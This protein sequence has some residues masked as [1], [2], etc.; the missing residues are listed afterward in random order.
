MR[1]RQYGPDVLAAGR[2]RPGQRELPRVAAVP[3]LV[4]ED[5][6]A[7]FCGAVVWC[8]KDAV[9]LEDA[10]GRQR[11]F[12]LSPGAFLLEG[13]PV[14]LVRPGPGR[15]AARCRPDCLGIDRRPAAPGQGR[16]GEPDLRR[17]PP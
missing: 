6:A 17:G 15:S 11:V 2:R 7:E 1:S 9:T 12:P 4:V 3:G 5:G 14:R 10:R 16:A 13:K 8:E